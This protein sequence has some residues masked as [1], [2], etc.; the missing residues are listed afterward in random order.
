MSDG[1]G[2]RILCIVDDFSREFLAAVVDSSLTGLKV[3]LAL[4]EV[5]AERGAP[6]SITVDNGT[7]V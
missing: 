4:S 1:R 3:A 2:F 5:V 7:E 6:V